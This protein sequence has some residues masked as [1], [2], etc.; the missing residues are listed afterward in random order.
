M[1]LYKTAIAF[2]KKHVVLFE[3]RALC[4]CWCWRNLWKWVQYALPQCKST[5]T[6]YLRL[7]VTLEW[8]VGVIF[9]QFLFYWTHWSLK[10]LACYN[11]PWQ[12]A[13]LIM[14][15]FSAQILYFKIQSSWLRSDFQPALLHFYC[16]SIA[17]MAQIELHRSTL[18]INALSC[19]ANSICFR[20][21]GKAVFQMRLSRSDPQVSRVQ[22]HK[23]SGFSLSVTIHLL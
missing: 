18:S 9:S 6:R 14:L 11:L 7:K 13:R 8:E 1:L 10:L 23:Q 21:Y 4:R 12:K 17:Y 20:T 22:A 3:T 19:I 16:S 15:L 5:L 2:L